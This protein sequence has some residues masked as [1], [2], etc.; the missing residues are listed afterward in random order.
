MLSTSRNFRQGAP[1]STAMCQLG[2]RPRLLKGLVSTVR[3]VSR[4]HLGM[5]FPAGPTALMRLRRYVALLGVVVALN[6]CEGGKEA[7]GLDDEQPT[8]SVPAGPSALHVTA[9]SGS[10]INL[11]WTDNSA[12][13][14]DHPTPP[15]EARRR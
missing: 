2:Q 10:Q 12:N 14:S 4:Q 9:M 1:R 11:A 8:A 6:A 15:R 3:L 7:V 5:P 13:E